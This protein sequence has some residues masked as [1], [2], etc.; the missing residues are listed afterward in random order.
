M[1][2]NQGLRNHVGCDVK[3]PL[4]HSRLLRC[5]NVGACGSERQQAV[6]FAGLQGLWQAVGGCNGLPGFE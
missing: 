1:C 4:P 6:F 3:C 5:D 2:D